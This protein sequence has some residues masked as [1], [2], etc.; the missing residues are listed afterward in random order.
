MAAGDVVSGAAAATA[1]R[2][3]A[4]SAAAMAGLGLEL[5]AGGREKRRRTLGLKVCL[6][7]V[8]TMV[9]QEKER[10]W[11][12]GLQTGKADLKSKG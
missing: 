2:E 8:F 10:R 5:P 12:G 11:R 1:A 4:G 9:G 7:R 3:V 6:P